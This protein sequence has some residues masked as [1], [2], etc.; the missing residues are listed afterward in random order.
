MYPELDFELDPE[1]D[2][3]MALADALLCFAWSRMLV[4]DGWTG[5]GHAKESNLPFEGF[6]EALC[7][8]SAL[9]AL[10]TDAEVNES[11]CLFDGLSDDIP[12]G[13]PHDLSDDL[14]HSLQVFDA[15][16]ADAFEYVTK[17]R[18]ADDE[19]FHKWVAQRNVDWGA[20]P[21]QPLA[22]AELPVATGDVVEHAESGD[23][24]AGRRPHDGLRQHGR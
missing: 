19:A 7:R 15:G 9:M 6:L 18:E 5:R 13:P 12:D 20:E 24:A 11:A 4:I 1:L 8:V 21:R 14:L 16:C 2:P 17:M 3:E 22:R 23:G 10:P